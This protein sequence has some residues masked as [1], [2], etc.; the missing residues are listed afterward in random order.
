MKILYDEAMPY[1][2]LFFD[3]L[4]DSKAFS[5]GNLNSEILKNTEALLVRSTTKIDQRLIKLAPKLKFVGTATAGFDHLDMDSLEDA[6][7]NVSIA[8]GCNAI[9]VAQYVLSAIAHLSN[10]D[11]FKLENKT[12]AIIG[13]GQVGSALS[14]FCE[15]LGLEY[16]LYD[17]PLQDAGDPRAFVS[18]E[19]ALAC[20][21]V[22]LHTPLVVDGPYP[23][24]HMFDNQ[25]LK[26]L[27]PEQYLINACRGE[28]I[29]NSA[30]L[31]LFE[32]GH[33]LN[34]V[35][36]VWENEPCIEQKLI[37]F[38]RIAT[39][40][41]AGHT[42]EGK[43]RGTSMLYDALCKFTTQVNEL[44]LSAFLPSYDKPHELKSNSMQA[45]LDLCLE[46]Y[47]ISK[48]DRVFRAEMAQSNAFKEI[49]R[50]Y[51][52]RREYSAV[53]IVNKDSHANIKTHEIARKLGFDVQD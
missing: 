4:G 3:E 52:V 38:V 19:Q 47:D 17:P 10:V 2:S 23:T 22:C 13:A 6:G 50:N 31:A 42:L 1:G 37:P 33:N 9:A 51:P 35:L 11:D 46:V 48:D 7:I 21:I 43:A 5:V 45:I 30:L 12:L 15:A 18:I 49:R 34:V 40:H 8:S 24:L 41:I 44:Q 27:R 20:D 25:R 26:N 53:K 32:S 16:Y 29:D 14:G 36:D 39:A 28:V